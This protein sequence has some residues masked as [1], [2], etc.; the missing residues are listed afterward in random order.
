MSE[1]QIRSVE[2]LPLSLPLEQPISSSLGAYDHIDM[3]AVW[4]HTDHGP[5]GFGFNAGLGGH[6]APA[7]AR[8]VEDEL[9]PIAI[10]RDPMS[11]EGLWEA[12][13]ASNK[14]R[15]QGGIGAWA[16]SAIDIACW[17]IVAKVGGVPLHSILGGYRRDVSVYGSG[18]WLSLEDDALVSECQS[19]VELGISTY[20]YKVGGP[21]DKARTEILR[22][23]FGDDLVLLA[24]ANQTFTVAEAIEHSRMLADSGVAWLEEPVLAAS[25][26]DLSAVAARSA[27]PIAAGENVYFRWGFREI[28]SR[29]GAA[30]LQPDVARCGG[31]TEFSKVLALAAS[32]QVHVTSHLWHEL[33]ISLIGASAA[34]LMAEYAP[35]LP[36]DLLARPFPVRDGSITVPDVPGHGVEL[37]SDAVSRFGL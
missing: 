22:R 9:A 30:F 29:Q 18:G 12:L 11:P 27:V 13:W 20:K 19:F 34:G 23:E 10:G 14:P 24:D 25:T 3:T 32:H 37:T 26:D 15:L 1:I 2:V 7:I 6:A 28:C 21:R 5:T 35:L 17:D 36:S 16:L 4:L 33:S 31:V 8:Y